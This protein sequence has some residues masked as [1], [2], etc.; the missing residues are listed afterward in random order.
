MLLT[1]LLALAG[2]VLLCLMIAAA[3]YF[4]PFRGMASQNQ[5]D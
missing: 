1:I 3:T 4:M 2:M 5:T